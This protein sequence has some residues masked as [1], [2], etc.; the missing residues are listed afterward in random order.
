MHHLD[1]EQR[2]GFLLLPQVHTMLNSTLGNRDKIDV[3]TL[4][5]LLPKQILI[6]SRFFANNSLGTT[7]NKIKEVRECVPAGAGGA[8]CCYGKRFYICFLSFY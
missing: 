7:A 3:S 2:D 8:H 5:I 6:F 1:P 4:S